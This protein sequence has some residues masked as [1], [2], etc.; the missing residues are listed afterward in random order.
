M[1]CIMQS[2][3]HK[4]DKIK[5]VLSNYSLAESITLYRITELSSM[6]YGKIVLLRKYILT[7]EITFEV[8]FYL[9]KPNSSLFQM[10]I[11]LNKR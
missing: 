5:V 2:A 7:D 11:T 4:N 10:M 8:Q 3:N 1:E 6:L 9:L